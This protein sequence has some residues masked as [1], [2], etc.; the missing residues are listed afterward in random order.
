VLTGD[1]LFVND[2]GRPDLRAS[3][4]WAPQDLAG[5]LYDSLHQKLMPLPGSTRVYPAHGAGSLCGKALGPENSST[6]DTQRR[7]N[8]ALQPMTKE[9]FIRLV[10]AGQPEPPPYFTYDAVLNTKERPTLER[11]LERS[12]KP[13][14]LEAVLE[15]Q[16]QGGQLLDVREPACFEAAHLVGSINI[17]LEGQYATW[18]GTLLDRERPIVVI[19]EPGREYEAAMRLGR[20]G[21]DGVAGYLAHGMRAAASRPELV[22]RTERMSPEGLS[23]ELAQ[24]SLPYLLDVRAARESTQNRIEGSV[25]IPL[26]QLAA[27]IAEVPRG[28]RIVVYCAGGYRSSIAASLLK[29]HGFTNVADLAGG[30]RAWLAAQAAS[31][32]GVAAAR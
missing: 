28:R 8:Y 14:A 32:T 16:S 22:A 18:A 5:L 6:I 13:L 3:L 12:L 29:H 27:R 1:T 23:Q 21:F 19:A 2:V 10:V 25:N 24:A 17:S 7:V 31:P 4:G 9:E 11:V 15:L 30:M 20:I 26:N